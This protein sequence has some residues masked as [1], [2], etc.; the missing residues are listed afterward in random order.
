MTNC[1]LCRSQHTVL[2][3]EILTDVIF[4]EYLKSLGISV[5]EILSDTHKIF[6]YECTTC[7]YKFYYPY[8]IA[9]GE[10]FYS[11]LGKL[12]W[13]YM[14]EKWEHDASI[15]YLKPGD[16][17]LEIGCGNGAFMKKLRKK[18]IDSEGLELNKAALAKCRND[19]LSVREQTIEEYSKN[20]AGPYDIV[21]SFQVLEH[22]SDPRSFL[23]NSLKKL[24]T[25]GLMIIAVPNNDSFIQKDRFPIL[26]MPPHHFGLYGKQT[27]ASLDKMI[28]VTV[29]NI[30]E[31][32]LQRHHFQYFYYVILGQ[33]IRGLGFFGKIINRL[34][35][36]LLYPFI[37]LYSPRV[38][39][40]TILAT[41]KKK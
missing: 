3:K 8:S 34:M 13:Y 24:K 37:L 11:K 41:Y 25:G 31:E 35:F 20:E 12:P 10:S 19:K 4:N 28:P 5:K 32:P 33:Y 9:A 36:Y 30:I 27:L 14:Q 1:P 15:A 39:G 16:R 2:K 38:I 40:H 22:I 26:N 17:V 23:E 6:Q 29:I 7:G 18:G 21:C